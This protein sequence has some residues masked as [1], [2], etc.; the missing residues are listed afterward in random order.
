MERSAIQEQKID[1]VT[2][3]FAK[4]VIGVTLRANRPIDFIRA[5]GLPLSALHKSGNEGKMAF[6]ISRH[7]GTSARQS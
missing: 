6:Q 3:D 4:P 1:E 5:T 7:H 2:P